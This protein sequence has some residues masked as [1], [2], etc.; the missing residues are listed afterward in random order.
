[1]KTVIIINHSPTG[2]AIQ[3]YLNFLYKFS[4]T[5]INFSELIP[6]GISPYMNY[7]L[8]ITDIYDDFTGK[9]YGLQ[10]GNLFEKN[11]KRIIYFFTSYLFKDNYSINDLP[12]NCFY[13]P[14]QLLNFLHSLRNNITNE[15]SSEKLMLI[16]NSNPITSSHH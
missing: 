9:N 14:S 4:S 1:M 11:Q 2:K 7:D 16:L 3:R 8:I 13:I 6:N 10:F 15:H 5:I 12:D